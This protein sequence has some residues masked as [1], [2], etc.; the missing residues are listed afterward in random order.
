MACCLSRSND[1]RQCSRVSRI[2]RRESSCICTEVLPFRFTGA[3][4]LLR[5]RSIGF[6]LCRLSSL[7]KMIAIATKATATSKKTFTQSPLG[8]FGKHNTLRYKPAPKNRGAAYL[9][10]WPAKP[11]KAKTD[12]FLFSKNDRNIDEYSVGK[13][14][15]ARGAYAT[16]CRTCLQR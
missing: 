3:T 5:S 11:T 10:T 7:A 4:R 9:N 16:P 2:H 14:R 13:I 8:I 12:D 15:P 1:W 6:S